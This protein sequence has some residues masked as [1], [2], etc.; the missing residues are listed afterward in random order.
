MKFSILAIA[1][2]SAMAIAATSAGAVTVTGA[3]KIT[4]TNAVPTWLQVAEVQ[5]FNFTPIN[6][7]L[8][9]NGGMAIGSSEYDST[10]PAAR[11][12]DGNTGGNYGFGEIFHSASPGGGEFLNISFAASN[13][14]SLSIFGRTDAGN[15]RDVY[16]VTIFNA[17]GSTLYSGQLSAVGQTATVNFD[18]AVVPEPGSWALMVLG[19]GLVGFAARRR[20]ASAAA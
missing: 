7:A 4:I 9:S 6:V 8:A 18:A 10:T 13:L 19:F 3:T 15:N 14:S 17:L 12:I 1:A 2:A 11:A 16:N 20:S 5:A